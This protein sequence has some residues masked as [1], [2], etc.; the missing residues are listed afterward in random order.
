MGE[1]R[2]KGIGIAGFRNCLNPRPS[3]IKNGLATW[4]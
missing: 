1:N 4:Q 3:R 2:E